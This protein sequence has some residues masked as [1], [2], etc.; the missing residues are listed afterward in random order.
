MAFDSGDFDT[1]EGLNDREKSILKK[2]GGGGVMCEG[3]KT[4]TYEFCVSFYKW[5]LPIR[6]NWRFLERRLECYC[7]K[8]L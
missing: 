4:R 1:Q 5:L 3:D 8:A 2:G 7:S 6:Y